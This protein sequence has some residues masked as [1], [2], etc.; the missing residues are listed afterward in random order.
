MTFNE[1]RI[2]MQFSKALKNE[3]IILLD[4]AIGTEL[5]KRG[6]MGR[7]SNNLDAPDAVLDIQRRYAASGCD[8]LTAN[9]LTMNR[10]YIETHNLGISVQ[11][12]NKAG[13]ELARRASGGSL[14][15]LGNLSSTGQLLEPYGTYRESQ[16][17][18]AF[19]EQAGILAEAGVDGFII[20]TMF[21]LR[22]ALCAL[23]ACKENFSL[24]AIVSIAFMTEEKG[25]RTMM[26]N[27]AEQCARSLTDAGADVIGANCGNLDPAQ[28]AIVVSYLKSATTLPLLAQPNAGR[29]KLVG[30]K[31]VFE[32]AP[33]QFADGIAECIRAG[34]RLVGGCC[35]TSP[36]HI[37][38]VAGTLNRPYPS[39]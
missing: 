6:L 36:Q 23:R 25:G 19:R 12:V 24:P 2:L 17:Y 9:T 16:F 8:A 1:Q 7:A 13:V 20:E 27:S 37:R 32:M 4:G 11:E 18:D 21:D 39:K 35:G 26:G 22:E 38:A 5:D 10:I 34:A 15:V 30:D 33:A 14:Y 31:T 28:M 29:P 3:G